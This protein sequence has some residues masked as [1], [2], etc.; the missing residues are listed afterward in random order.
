L[1]VKI[2]MTFSGGFIDYILYGLL[3]WDRSHALLVIPVGIVYAIVYYFLFDFAIRKFKLKTPGREDKQSQAVTASA[4]ELPYAVLEAMG[5]KANIKHLD[6]C[7]TRL[8]VEVN[9]KSKV[10]VPGLKDLGASGV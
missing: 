8:R 5:G 1:G 10:D 2:G 9:D 7:I 4:T 3:N 6:A